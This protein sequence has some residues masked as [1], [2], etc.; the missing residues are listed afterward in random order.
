[1]AKYKIE[2]CDDMNLWDTFVNN[3]PQGTVFNNSNFLKTINDNNNYYF[4]KKGEEILS[5]FTLVLDLNNL[6]VKTIPFVPYINNIMFSEK[7]S[8][9]SHK[10]INEE[11]KITELII[12][13]VLTEFKQFHVINS[14][15]FNDIRPFLWYNYHNS[16]NG[17]FKNKVWYTPIINLKNQ[18]QDTLLSQLRYDRKR[19]V[20]K[21]SS[22]ELRE[23]NDIS[24]LNRLHEQTFNRQGINRSALEEDLLLKI[25]KNSLERGYGRLAHIYKDDIPISST[26]FLFDK[27]SSYYLFGA[28]STEFR[29]TGASSKLL[30]DNIMFSYNK[31]FQKIDLVG[32]NSPDRSS[33]KIS[34]NA[35]LKIYFSSSLIKNK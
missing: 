31:G 1:M 2:L 26:L 14:P 3:S 13:E 23:S 22:L 8:I 6:P 10:K 9:L 28:S 11:F 33:F 20:K 4:V 17:V 7:K 34:F 29:N 21:S 19:D 12:N 27:N 30:F 15:E 32:A 16:E 5:A 18:D 24:V 35:D 25:A